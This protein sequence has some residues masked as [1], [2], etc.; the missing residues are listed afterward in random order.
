PAERKG[1]SGVGTLTRARPRRVRV[2]IGSPEHD[3]EGRV[4]VTELPAVTVLNVYAPSGTM[5]EV[6]Q[7]VKMQFLDRFLGFVAELLAEGRPLLLCGD[8][9]IAHREVDLKNW[10]SNQKSSGFL[11]EERAWFG[12]LLGLGLVDVVRR[13]AGDET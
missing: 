1:Y 8:V 13:L 5:G 2:G 3:S 6:R 10:R 4:L 7:A 11:P 12:E 9:N